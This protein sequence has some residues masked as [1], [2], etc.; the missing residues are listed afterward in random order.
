MKKLII[1]EKPSVA[2]NISEAVD[3]K[4]KQNGYLEGDDYIISWAYGHLLQLFDADDYQEELSKW[5][6]ETIPFF[7]DTFQYKVKSANGNRSK[8]DEGAKKQLMIIQSLIERNDVSDI[9]SATD[10]DREGQVIADEIFEYLQVKKPIWRLL[11]SEWTKDEVQRGLKTLKPNHEMLPLH[12]AG[13]GRQISDWMIGINITR[14]A[15]LKYNSYGQLIN[16]G[17]VLIPTLK[18]IYD[19]DIEIEKFESSEYFRLV[20]EFETDDHRNYEGTYYILDN[21]TEADLADNKNSESIS[22]ENDKYTEKIE[23]KQLL[24]DVKQKISGQYGLITDKK[25]EKKREKAP[26]LFNLTNLQGFITGKYKGWTSDKVLKVAQSLYEKK[27]ITYP[28]TASFVLDESI[29]DKTRKV[30]DILYQLAPFRD[31][32][33]FH[34]DKRVF[35]SSKVDSH[36]AIIPTYQLPKDSSLSADEKI[37]YQTIRNRFLAQ[38]MPESVSEETVIKTEFPELHIEGYFLTKGKVLIEE[39]WKAVEQVKTKTVDLPMLQKDEKVK[40]LK[41][42]L[43]SVKR[44]P[45]KHHTEKTLL[46]V[47]ETCGKGVD[48]SASEDDLSEE[49]MMSILSGFSIGTPATRAETIKKLVDVGYIEYQKKNLVCTNLG[50]KIVETLPVEDLLDLNFTGKLEKTLS[51]IERNRF[52]Q[53]DFLD[54]IK[55]LVERCVREIKIGASFHSDDFLGDPHHIYGVCPECG[56]DIV[57]TK[58]SFGCSNWRGGCKYTIWKNDKFIKGFGKEISPAMIESICKNGKVGLRDCV[59]KKGSKFSAYFS[60]V[61]DLE[62]GRYNWKIDYPNERKS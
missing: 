43:T 57:E 2:R 33:R 48:D 21:K 58:N 45:P 46:K 40:E 8:V 26:Y 61:K 3:A 60:Y 37:V 23:N 35:D 19:R 55:D 18:I 32:L 13:F 54:L 30:F 15:T 5:D 51:D 42:E 39:G 22:E 29:I 17:R 20:S 28:R 9:I 44:Q 56:G 16:V 62:S 38:F 47:M 59:S 52:T 49:M 50:K 14:A 34:T 27:Y 25:V 12:D 41:S 31:Q 6:F 10:D 53:K 36:S 4:K 24:E 7:P 1:A 11:L